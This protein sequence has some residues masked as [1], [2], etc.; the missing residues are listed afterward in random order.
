MGARP[1]AGPEGEERQTRPR[2]LAQIGADIAIMPARYKVNG[3]DGR[4]RLAA[5]TVN[6]RRP[7]AGPWAILRGTLLL[8]MLL[9]SVAPAVAT[10]TLFCTIDDRNVSFELLGNTRIED[11]AIVA[12]HRGRLILKPS[13]YVKRTAVFAITKQDIVEQRNFGDDLSFAVHAAD[14][15]GGR[16]I[17]L[18]IVATRDAGVE[19]YVGSHVLRLVRPSVTRRLK[20]AT[21]C[22]GD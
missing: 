21:T 2:I 11:G 20:G 22:E 7:S 6:D 4:M 14:A 1:R 10:G 5:A 17:V 9:Q 19:K 13:R 8:V 18:A 16:S 15:G 3:E 12:V